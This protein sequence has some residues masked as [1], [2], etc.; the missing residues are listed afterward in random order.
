[1]YCL[2]VQVPLF[3][4]SIRE[5]LSYYTGSSRSGLR[6]VVKLDSQSLLIEGQGEHFEET[7]TDLLIGRVFGFGHVPS[8]AMD[9]DGDHGTGNGEGGA[10]ASQLNGVN[11]GEKCKN[12]RHQNFV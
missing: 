10:G 6:Q 9:S 11:A 5:F 4:S 3:S 12:S 1:M 7:V 8:I 2:V